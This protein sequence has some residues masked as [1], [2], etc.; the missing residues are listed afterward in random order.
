MKSFVRQDFYLP[1][2]NKGASREEWLEWLAKDDAAA[3]QA[4]RQ[5]SKSRKDKDVDTLPSMSVMK[6]GGV[7]KQ[8]GH[9]GFVGDENHTRIEPVMEATQEVDVET[10]RNRLNALSHRSHA[11]G[12]HQGRREA[13]RQARKAKYRGRWE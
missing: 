7:F 4:R 2:P 11:K 5:F 3:T 10:A 6:V 9:V 13:I 12:N 8:V 1:P